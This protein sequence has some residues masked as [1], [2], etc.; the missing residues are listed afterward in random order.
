MR[1]TLTFKVG[2]PPRGNRTGTFSF[3]VNHSLVLLP[4]EPMQMRLADQRVGWFT[5][6][7][8]DY[9]SSALKSDDFRVAVRWRMEPKDVAAYNRGEL[10]E[11]K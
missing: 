2:D 11:P 5:L 4:E 3:Q 6:K 7:K 10:V 1:H 8:I 9:S